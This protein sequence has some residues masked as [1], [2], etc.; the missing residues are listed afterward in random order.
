MAAIPTSDMPGYKRLH[1]RVCD[2]LD[3][4]QESEAVDFKRGEDW[5]SLRHTVAKTAMA[6]ANQRDGGLIVIGASETG[7]EWDLS[8]ISTGNLESYE[9][10]TMIDFI[11]R[12]ASPALRPDVVVV[13]YTNGNRFLAI[14]ISEFSDT[15][16]VCCRNGPNGIVEGAVY[17]RAR[18]KAETKRVMDAAEMHG[19]LDLAGEKRA[20]RMIEQSSRIGMVPGTTSEDEYRRE[21]GDS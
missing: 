9:V 3:Y 20:R 19:L 4:C 8:G 10:D 5:S 14:Q 21:R 11:N 7:D 18:G 15:P 1:D 2:A 13:K 16:V 6:M 17:V 12:Y